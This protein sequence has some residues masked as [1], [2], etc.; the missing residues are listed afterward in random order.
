[1]P[2]FNGEKFLPQALDSLLS[3]TYTD[4]ELVVSDNASTDRTEEIVREA[5]L[6][7]AR[8][9][10]HRN[11]TNLGAALNFNQVFRMSTGE[12]FKWA[13][14]DDLCAP[15]FLSECV[16]V[17]DAHADVVL[18]YPKT[19]I[20][21]QDDREIGLYEDELDL[22]AERLSE[23]YA[24]FHRRFKT[25]KECNAVFGLIRAEP[26][27]KTRLIGS[28][29]SSDI[30]LLSELALLGKYYEIPIPLFFRRDHPSSSIRAN[31]SLKTRT[32]W[33]DPTRARSAFP[34]WK[35]L[36][37][38]IRSLRR[39]DIGALNRLR[40]YAALGGWLGWNSRRLWKEI[41]EALVDQLNRLPAPLARLLHATAHSWRAV[42]RAFRASFRQGR[43]KI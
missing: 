8:I 21:D 5:M 20:I 28:Y 11:E 38:F 14:A 19:V 13:S 40:C 43:G 42:K 18:A 29:S 12:Y 37:E 31:P 7:D 22:R 35:L 39:L 27:R 4:F 41:Q 17:L 25:L 23:R 32:A 30:V 24:R 10:Y 15:R 36:F 16:A 9:R 6:R 3:Q 33:F 1:M 34:R 26:L 2:V